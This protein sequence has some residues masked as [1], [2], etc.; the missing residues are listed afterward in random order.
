MNTLT[1]YVSSPIVSISRFDHPKFTPHQD[2]QEETASDY[3]IN[4]IEKGTYSLRVGTRKW[5][6]S[7]SDVFITQPGMIFSC[8]HAE[9]FP[10]DVCFSVAYESQFLI[11]Q[12]EWR[13]LLPKQSGCV[14]GLNNR[15]AYLY[16]R[17][18]QL[19]ISQADVLEAETLASDLLIAAAQRQ[20]SGAHKLHNGRQ[21]AWYVERVEAARRL[22]ETAHCDSHSLLSLA[23]FT[24]MS[25]FHFARIFRELT[26][27]PPHRFLM[28]VRM[29]RASEM[30]LDGVSVTESCFASGFE[31][32]S[33][34]IRL[35]KRKF[36][37]SP[38]RFSYRKVQRPGN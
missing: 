6:M 13:S 35:F 36:G 16:M 17:L 31:N 14:V 22:M 23:R 38:S 32:L 2:P 37:V 18:N 28:N 19:T 12:N 5:H 10:E 11:Q 7:R 25:P 4:F 8:R 21:L 15:L 9:E 24:G 1:N 27:T 29:A 34:F 3:S 26:G 30:L 20:I 33:H